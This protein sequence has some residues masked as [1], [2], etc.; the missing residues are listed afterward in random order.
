MCG[1]G[2]H[3]FGLPPG[4]GKMA[5]SRMQMPHDP[6]ESLNFV[7]EWPG[8]LPNKTARSHVNPIQPIVHLMSKK[9]LLTVL[10]SGLI[11]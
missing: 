1:R 6:A 2:A 10:T 8:T 9:T 11:V 3:L 5:K 4:A 7:H